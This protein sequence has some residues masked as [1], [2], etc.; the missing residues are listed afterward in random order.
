MTDEVRFDELELMD[1][2]LMLKKYWK[3]IIS[4]TILIMLII[5]IIT[6]FFIQPKYTSQVVFE[7]YN[8]PDSRTL[9]RLEIINTIRSS[10]F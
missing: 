10:F 2:I 6:I 3:L 5:G 1:V 8:P 4:L 7:V 9:S